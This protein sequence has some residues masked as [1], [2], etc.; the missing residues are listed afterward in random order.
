MIDKVEKGLGLCSASNDTKYC[1]QCPYNCETHCIECLSQNALDI[2]IKLQSENK[3]LKEELDAAQQEINSM[4][5]KL[6]ME[7]E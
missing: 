3:A 7:G 4:K 1:W 2:L 6:R 5:S